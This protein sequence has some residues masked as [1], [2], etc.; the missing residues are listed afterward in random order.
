MYGIK[1]VVFYYG[2]RA[3]VFVGI[4]SGER[5]YVQVVWEELAARDKML[6]VFV[7]GNRG[8]SLPVLHARRFKGK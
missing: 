4:R 2:K 6:Q 5:H 1:R 8:N 7:F 3:S